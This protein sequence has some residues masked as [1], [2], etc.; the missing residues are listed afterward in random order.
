V[1]SPIWERDA[2]P[3]VLL[4][5]DE[6]SVRR[7]LQLFLTGRGYRVRSFS[8]AGPAAAD[9]M[10]EDAALLVSDYRLPDSDG[11]KLLAGLRERGWAGRAILVTA[12]P[13]APLRRAADVAG[14]AAVIEKPLRHEDLL[15]A[16]TASN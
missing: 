5:E 16:L 9:P 6:D 13:S 10:F 1:S 11:L 4:V 3:L 15:S 7:S 12:Y 8:A 2:R 14:Y